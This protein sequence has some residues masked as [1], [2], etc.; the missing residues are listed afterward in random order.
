MCR[1]L[2]AD[3]VQTE[4]VR[5]LCKVLVV[6]SGEV[7]KNIAGMTDAIQIESEISNVV[8]FPDNFRNSIGCNNRPI[9][10]HV[11]NQHKNVLFFVLHPNS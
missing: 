10:N 7:A 4:H 6:V 8:I 5:D 1:S 2:L 11:N 3:A 9:K